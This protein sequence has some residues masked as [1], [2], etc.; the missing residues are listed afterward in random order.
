MI[1]EGKKREREREKDGRRRDYGDVDGEA[2][3]MHWIGYY[4][5]IDTRLR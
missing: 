3:T 4:G 1:I 2:G 5:S